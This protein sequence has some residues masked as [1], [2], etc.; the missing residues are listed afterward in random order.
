MTESEGT[1]C[2]IAEG[3]KIVWE[4]YLSDSEFEVFWGKGLRS[5]VWLYAKA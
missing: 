2:A 4:G 5:D 3:G 1:Y